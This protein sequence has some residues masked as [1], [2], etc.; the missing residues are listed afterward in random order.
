MR[1]NERR[2]TGISARPLLW[3]IVFYSVIKAAVPDGYK[4][5]CNATRTTRC[6][7]QIVNEKAESN[8]VDFGHGLESS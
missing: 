4:V 6:R 2:P 5:I 1:N 7:R 3:N 8:G